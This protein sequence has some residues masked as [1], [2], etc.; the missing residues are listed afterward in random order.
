MSP[1]QGF[2]KACTSLAILMSAIQALKSRRDDI[3][4]EKLINNCQNSERVILVFVNIKFFR[5]IVM[6][7]LTQASTVG[8]VPTPT[9][10]LVLRQ[11]KIHPPKR[12]LTY[13]IK[14]FLSS[15]LQSVTQQ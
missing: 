15:F 10:S 1:L 8:G 2:L 4:L 14:A 7:V 12:R 9:K 6:G 5:T 3:T 11:F 13:F